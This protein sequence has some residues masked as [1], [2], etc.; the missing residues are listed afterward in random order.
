METLGRLARDAFDCG[1]MVSLGAVVVVLTLA[2]MAFGTGMGCVAYTLATVTP[3]AAR[4][5]IRRN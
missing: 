4:R 2:F 1:V 3:G 5:D